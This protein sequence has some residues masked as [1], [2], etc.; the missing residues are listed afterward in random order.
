MF[1]PFP[2][3][4]NVVVQNPDGSAPTWLDLWGPT[5][6]PLLVSLVALGGVIFAN[7]RTGKNM[8]AA[9]RERARLAEIAEDKRA[10]LAIEADDRRAKAAIEAEDRRHAND[11]R[12][13]THDH[14]VDS[15]RDLYAAVEDARRELSDASYMVSEIYSAA[16][17]DGWIEYGKEYRERFD[18][19]LSEFRDVRARLSLLGSEKVGTLASHIMG[20]AFDVA[21]AGESLTGNSEMPMTKTTFIE[22]RKKNVSLRKDCNRLLRQMR[23]E[24]DRDEPRPTQSSS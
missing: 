4:F 10:K 19:A 6:V 2:D 8:I 3:T 12:R 24:L 14:M 5:V 17:L 1:P 15:I 11:L 18:K 22:Y 7:W 20:G 16:N 23:E 21:M 9:E 13:A